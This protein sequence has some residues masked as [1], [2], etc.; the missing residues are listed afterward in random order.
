MSNTK[1]PENIIAQAQYGDAVHFVCQAP[2]SEELTSFILRDSLSA[3][4]PVGLAKPGTKAAYF[5]SDS[6]R[7]IIALLDGNIIQD[8]VYDDAEYEWVQGKLHNLNAVVSPDS[9]FTAT[10]GNGHLRLYIKNMAGV[11]QELLQETTGDW[12]YSTSLDAAK[13]ATSSTMSAAGSANQISVFYAHEDKS[14]HQI[15]YKNGKWADA[16]VP[17]TKD[18]SAPPA[19]ITAYP[20]TDDQSYGLQ[21]A[22]TKNE[23]FEVAF[24]RQKLK[25]GDITKD[26]YKS[27]TAA[28]CGRR[29]PTIYGGTHYWRW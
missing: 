17:E 14:I 12:Q 25:L 11:L 26:G 18:P 24:G 29:G 6:Q 9:P 20:P 15:M 10:Y 4:K 2:D 5:V 7:V 13:L 21:Y 16:E 23:V 8:Y 27:I 22:T 28:Q 19:K 3:P 1:H